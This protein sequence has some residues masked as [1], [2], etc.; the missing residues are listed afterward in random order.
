MSK[1]SKVALPSLEELLQAG[2]HFG[3]RS[4]RWNPKMAEFI[5]DKRDEV[6]IIDLIKTLKQLKVAIETLQSAGDRGSVL[7]VGTKGQ[8]AQMVK[9][10]A[11]EVGAFYV[12]TRWPGGLFTN[13]DMI[14][15]SV[16]KL[17]LME[18]KLAS[19]GEGL[20]K[21]EQLLLARD[22]ARLNRMYEG[23]KF[24]DRL[25]EVVVVID[26]RLEKNAIAEARSAGIKVV[27]LVDTNCDPTLVDYPIPAN[28]DSLKSIKLFLELFGKVIA[29]TQSS[30][31]V[32]NLRKDHSAKLHAAAAEY[33]NKLA[34]KAKEEAAA[35]ERLKKLRAGDASAENDAPQQVVRVVKKN[36]AKAA[37]PASS[38]GADQKDEKSNDVADLDLPKRAVDALVAAGYTK[39]NQIQKMSKSEL[40][41]L[42]G[43]GEVAAQKILKA[44]K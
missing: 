43:I 4:S 10:I 14:K 6:H 21:K 37:K 34:M 38:K 19:G 9:D 20:V 23:I 13:Y 1:D 32:I 3:H 18:E 29:Q 22:A 11:K 35:N 2:V 15:R 42:K 8:A 26:T 36:P 28:D 27:G 25:P 30:N 39:V 16:N 12:S 31:R 44:V 33:E 41:A 7:F 17:V 40:I 24:M 5:Y